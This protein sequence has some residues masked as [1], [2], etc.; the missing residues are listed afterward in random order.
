MYLLHIRCI[1]LLLLFVS[2]C[3]DG[4]IPP[5]IPPYIHHDYE[6]ALCIHFSD[7]PMLLMLGRWVLLQYGDVDMGQMIIAFTSGVDPGP[8]GLDAMLSTLSCN[9]RK[10]FEIRSF[11]CYVQGMGCF[12]ELAARTTK[13]TFTGR[14]SGTSYSSM[15]DK[16]SACGGWWPVTLTP[17]GMIGRT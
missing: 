2:T 13:F 3:A 16:Y 8:R 5:K 10:C 17:V 6:R 14:F 12:C 7:D 4:V 1:Y 15:C 9:E 11:T